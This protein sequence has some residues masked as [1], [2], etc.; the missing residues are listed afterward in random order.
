[1]TIKFFFEPN[2]HSA[3]PLSLLAGMIAATAFAAS[4][5]SYANQTVKLSVPDE[6]ATAPFDVPRTLDIPKGFTIRVFARVDGARFMAVAP[7][8]DL[9]VSNP[10]AG[11]ITLLR[12]RG[13]STPQVFTFASRLHNPHDIVFHVLNGNSYVY[14]AESNR[15]VRARYE[16]NQSAI[17]TLETLV[18]DLPDASSPG[19]KGRYGHQLKNITLHGDK[20]Y[21]S[22]AS[23]CNACASDTKADPVRA[24]IYEYDADGKNRRLYAQGLRNA[25]GVRFKPGTNELWR[26]S[27]TA[28][29]SFIPTI[30]S[31]TA[32]ARTITASPCKAMSTAIRPIFW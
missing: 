32:T 2:A 4:T 7:N 28:T 13:E 30:R 21:V 31:G 8:G 17:G 18:D 11:S 22:V 12:P 29:T 23:T 25:E 1:M 10:G 3:R 14:I 19:L 6:M 9:L 15:I 20:L 16:A 5:S 24:A 27:T 26:W